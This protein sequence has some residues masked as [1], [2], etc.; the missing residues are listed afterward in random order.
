MLLEFLGGNPITYDG[1]PVA[2]NLQ[3]YVSGD[4]KVRCRATCIMRDGAPDRP[5]DLIVYKWT[6]PKLDHLST[7][8]V[9][10]EGTE[11][12]NDVPYALKLGY[13]FIHRKWK[14]SGQF[15]GRAV[16]RDM[17]SILEIIAVLRDLIA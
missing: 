7:L 12:V 4:R 15:N 9:S 17:A 2:K 16:N 11:L 8:V 6:M 14:V 1:N 3:I 10:A 5:I 13:D